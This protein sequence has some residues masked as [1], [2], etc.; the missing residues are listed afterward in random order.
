MGHWLSA[1]TIGLEDARYWGHR[2]VDFRAMAGAF[3]RNL[4]RGRVIS[5]AST[6]TQQLIKLSTGRT[7]RSP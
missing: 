1:M 2:G 6:I 3:L 7:G 5:G 4:R